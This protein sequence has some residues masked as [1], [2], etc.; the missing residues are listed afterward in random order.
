MLSII[1]IAY[2]DLGGLKKTV[3]SLVDQTYKD[4]EWIIIDGGSTDGSKE[5]LKENEHLFT[6][7]V[8]EPDA[9]IYDAMNKGAAFA[10][11]EYLFFLNSD[12]DLQGSHALA[13]IA[14][15]LNGEDIIYAD[16]DIV[17]GKQRSIKKAPEK[18]SFRYIYDDLPAHQAT[19]IKRSL[20]EKMGGYDAS[21]KIVADWKFFALAVLKHDA[22][23]KYIGKP[24]SNFYRG[25]ISSKDENSKQLEEERQLILEKEF[26]ILLE[27][28]K[29]QFYLERK[30]RNL[31]KSRKVQWLQRLGL[32]DK[33]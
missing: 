31:R 33:F 25:G 21:L 27:D 2:N 22:T 6:Y 8:S 11:A 30:L 10:K 9:G 19:I 18:L 16:I 32:L 23:Y 13:N 12:D 5:F 3:S 4:F 17:D 29:R 28:V 1:T 7:Y 14:A 15:H 26:P 24:F 20:F